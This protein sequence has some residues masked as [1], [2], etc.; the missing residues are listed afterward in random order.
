LAKSPIPQ[1]FVNLHPR[2]LLDDDLYSRAAPLTAFASKVVLEVTERCPLD[3]VADVQSRIAA[4]RQL[5]FRIAIDDVG[6]GYAGLTSI[7]QLE[8][9]VMKIDME[10]VRDVDV[11]ATKQK[12]IGAMVNLCNEMQVL[13]ITEGVE[14]RL[15]R[16]AVQ[17]L[18]C[19]LMQGYLFAKPDKPFVDATF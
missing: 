11:S 4:L 5:G 7:A 18:G 17:R 19:D 6:A 9:E 14:T 2:D 12:L 1:V 3:E 16:D 8:P 15:E 10:L 13:V